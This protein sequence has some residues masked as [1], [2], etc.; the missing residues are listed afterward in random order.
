[1][2]RAARRA[3]AAR[4]APRAAAVHPAALLGGGQRRAAQGLPGRR[5]HRGAG[6]G[7]RLL[8]GAHAAHAGVR[9]AA[10]P[11][12][13][14]RC[15]AL[16]CPALRRPA[17]RCTTPP[18]P[19][20]HRP[21]LRCAAQRCAALERSPSYPSS[22]RITAC[23]GLSATHWRSAP[24]ILS[25]AGIAPVLRMRRRVVL[26]LLPPFC[27]RPAPSSARA[28]P[29][30]PQPAPAPA[31]QVCVPEQGGAVSGLPAMRCVGGGPL[32]AHAGA[33]RRPPGTGLHPTTPCPPLPRARSG[34][35]GAARPRRCAVGAELLSSA[36]LLSSASCRV[37]R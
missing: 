20:L 28:A 16:P 23:P 15:A 9:C 26:L 1:M 24:I 10:L 3:G 21:A 22:V 14:L 34:G 4:G 12:P 13:A 5:R 25:P 17:L 19:A 32:L 11:C 18:C 29:P 31:T 2:G 7:G 36:G 30:Q 6:A 33:P 8:R 27:S 37:P 35:A